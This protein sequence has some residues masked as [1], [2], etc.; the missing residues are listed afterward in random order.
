MKLVAMFIAGALSSVLF[1]AHAVHVEGKVWTL[2]AEEDLRCD[3]EGGCAILTK[4]FFIEEASKM[5]HEMAK[6]M[7]KGSRI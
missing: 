2:S 3:N 6:D 1:V 4:K 5:A 7:C